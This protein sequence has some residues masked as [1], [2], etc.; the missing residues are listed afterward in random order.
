MLRVALTGGI[1]TGKS[2]CLAGFEKLGAPVI[3]ADVLARQLVAKGTPG[4]S[5]VVQR[6]GRSVLAPDG[7]L[8]RSALAEIVFA[9]DVA[10]KDLEGVIHPLVY[11]RIEEWF[12]DV[13]GGIGIADIPLLYETRHHVQFDRVIVAACSAEQQV[14]RLLA[15]GMSREEARARLAAQLPIADKRAKADYVID[16]SGTLRDT[17]QQVADIWSQIKS[18]SQQR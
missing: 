4:L 17:D 2:H 15:R 8:D 12:A 16:T 6:F 1:A 3:D 18:D 5:A 7:G 14:E 10:R 11:A 13:S 9:D